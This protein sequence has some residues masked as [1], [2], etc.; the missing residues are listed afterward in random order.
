MFTDG[1]VT[2]IHLETLIDLLRDAGA[3]K[4]DAQTVALLLQPEGLPKLNPDR[5]Q[6]KQAL[7][8]AE[9]LGLAKRQEGFLAL[10]IE[11][12]DKRS[13][14]EIVLEALDA[15]VLASREAEP[16]FALYYS[17][18]LGLGKKAGDP[19]KTREHWVSEFNTQV[20]GSR[21]QPDQFNETKLTGLH[22][23]FRYAGLGWYDPADVFQCNPYERLRRALPK[24]FDGKRKLQ[25][26]AFMEG[27]ARA[28]AELDGG[29]IFRQAVPTY[30]DADRVCSLGLSHAL[31]D[32]HLDAQI[33]L[34]C[35]QDSGGWSM[36]EADPL[37]LD[38]QTF[39]SARI[40]FVELPKAR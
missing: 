30:N 31:V 3:R 9:D 38:N 32:L 11:R 15:R 23:W 8:A 39:R 29:A 17:Y 28:C 19:K 22:R 33:I 10:T 7:A 36:Q 12:K 25:G 6:T 37:P 16:Y 34:H 24:I 21:K 2:P 13:T 5:G 35:S 1:P 14:R 27:L 4:L 18:L 26:G 40:D 20:F